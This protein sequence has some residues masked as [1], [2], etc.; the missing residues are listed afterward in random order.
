MNYPKLLVKERRIGKSK[1]YSRMLTE[2]PERELALE[3]EDRDNEISKVSK[4]FY[5]ERKNCK[6]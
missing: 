2:S 3:K 4:R 5:S 1:G 6:F